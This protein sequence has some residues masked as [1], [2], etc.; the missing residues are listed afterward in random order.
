M[1]LVEKAINLV[2]KAYGDEVVQDAAGQIAT[3]AEAIG[4]AS[5]ASPRFAAAGLILSAVAL[6]VKGGEF[7]AMAR[8]ALDEFSAAIEKVK[9]EADQDAGGKAMTTKI[10]VA[11][12]SRDL[13]RA[14]RVIAELRAIPGVEVSVDWPAAMRERGPDEGLSDDDRERLAKADARGAYRADV[15]LLLRPTPEAPSAGAWVE[16]GIALGA[17]RSPSI[18]VAGEGTPCIFDALIPRDRVVDTDGEA[19]AIVRRIVEAQAT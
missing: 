5:A 8:D 11:G 10:Y 1:S 4:K 16:L 6:D 13:P 7:A 12:S 19:V 18:L 9:R 17:M 15:L 3:M 14:E 2:R